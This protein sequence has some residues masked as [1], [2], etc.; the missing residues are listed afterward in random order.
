NPS[1]Q[2]AAIEIRDEVVQIC[3]H[4][5]SHEST[6]TRKGNSTLNCFVLSC[7]RGFSHFIRNLLRERERP[8]PLFARD[9]WRTPGRDRIHEVGELAF[10]R[11][12][13]LNRD[14]RAF[15]GR[16]RTVSLDQ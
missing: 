13:A 2:L 15:N 7:F 16:H 5:S 10:E 1:E 8:A 12:L 11:L 4:K 3:V 9:E 6:K 14:V